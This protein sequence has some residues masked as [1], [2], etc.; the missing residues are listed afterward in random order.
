MAL[1]D[2]TDRGAVRRA[3]DEFRTLGQQG[4]LERYGFGASRGW[5]LRDDDG[6]EYDAKAI[7]AQRMAT[8][9]L[10]WGLSLG[11]TSTE[12]RQQLASSAS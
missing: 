7:L 12:A 8:S 6:Q 2:I 10:P 4:F 3:I 1:E 5:M 11:G 9:I